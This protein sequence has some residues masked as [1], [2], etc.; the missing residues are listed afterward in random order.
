MPLTRRH[1]ARVREGAARHGDGFHEIASRLARR[2]RVDSLVVGSGYWPRWTTRRGAALVWLVETAVREFGTEKIVVRG[3]SAGAHLAVLT[4]CR[5]RG[6]H[7]CLGFSGVVLSSGIY[8]L[9]PTPS[10]RNWKE[11]KLIWNGQ[12]LRNC[13]RWLAESAD[14]D[15]PD[16]SPLFSD[17]RKLP[18]A[19]L[20]VGTDEAL[21]DDTL[22]LHARWKRAVGD[23]DRCGSGRFSRT[24][25]GRDTGQ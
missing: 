18:P 17:L 14:L 6:R 20:V 1:R 11:R 10:A 16:V 5:L 9:R 2:E 24:G 4:L 22:F 12:T 3:S 7:D 15:S 21:I 19:L 8:D 23:A 13:V 25:P